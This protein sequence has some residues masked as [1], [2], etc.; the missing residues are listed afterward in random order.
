MSSNAPKSYLD[1]VT[2][3]PKLSEAWDLM[4]ESGSSA[5]PIDARTQLLI[6]LGIA[7]GSGR[8]GSVSSATRKGLNNGVTM[9]E[10]E[11]VIALAASTIGLPAA[12]AAL[13]WS[14]AVEQKSPSND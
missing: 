4:R 3:F 12:V 1:F 9:E 2:R 13:Q 8:T 11:Q 6:K 5:G 14:R 7:I 10:L